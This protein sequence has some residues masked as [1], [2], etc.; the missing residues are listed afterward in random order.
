MCEDNNAKLFE[1]GSFPLQTYLPE[2][3][4]D[5]VLILPNALAKR[6]AKSNSKFFDIF[7]ALCHRI[8]EEPSEL[9]TSHYS[10]MSIR[11]VEY[12]NARTK[13]CHCMVNSVGVDITVNQISALVSASFLEEVDRI[14]G[15]SNLFKRSV[16]LVK[17]VSCV[18]LSAAAY[19]IYLFIAYMFGG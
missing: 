5:L 7:H 19:L 15:H 8:E 14:I 2:S 1:S 6:D 9:E 13:V 3:D 17:V 18:S 10:P 4:L 11:S 12:V 16:I